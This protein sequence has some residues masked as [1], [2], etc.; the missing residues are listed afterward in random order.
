MNLKES[1]INDLMA[2]CSSKLIKRS[3]EDEQ[4][5]INEINNCNHLF[6]KL[7]DYDKTEFSNINL[8]VYECVHCG[9]TNK[10]MDLETTIPKYRKS[11]KYFILTKLHYTDFEFKNITNESIMMN[12][13]SIDYINNNLMSD[14]VLRSLHPGILYDIARLIN[15]DAT[16]EELFDIMEELHNLETIEERKK[17][18]TIFDAKELI[19]RYFNT[20]DKEYI[21][22]TEDIKVYCKK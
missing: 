20:I 16:N 14:K 9:V 18:N 13:I 10:F 2:Q 8:T 11:A 15:E 17:L 12:G 6:V 21:S 7:R 1:I 22:D 3:D 5:R 19:E 4:K